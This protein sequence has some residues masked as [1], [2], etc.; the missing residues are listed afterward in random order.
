[1]S[2]AQMEVM[3]AIMRLRAINPSDPT[4]YRAQSNGERVTLAS[5]W[6]ARVLDRRPWRGVVG[7]PDTAYEYTLSAATIEALRS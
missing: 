6:R 5:L 7:A 1:M 4:W 3:R 2:P